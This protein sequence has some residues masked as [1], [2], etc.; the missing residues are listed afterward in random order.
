MADSAAPLIHVTFSCSAAGSLKLA[1]TTLARNEE[2]LYLADDLAFGPIN[3]PEPR[4][5][6]EWSA[7]QLGGSGDPDLVAH[8]EAFW[9]RI[10]AHRGE[11]FVWIS[12]R[13]ATEVLR[14]SRVA[15]A[16]ADNGTRH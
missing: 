13:Y 5:R 7:E 8:D 11:I 6:A 14:I 2:V 12:R 10:A 3:P 1:L 15:L 16:R 9:A 4:R